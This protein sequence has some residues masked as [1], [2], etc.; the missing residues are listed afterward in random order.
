M[1]SSAADSS[2]TP[3]DTSSKVFRGLGRLWLKETCILF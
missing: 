1:S 2:R 3:F